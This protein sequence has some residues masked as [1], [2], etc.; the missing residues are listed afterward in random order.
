MFTFAIIGCGKIAA[1]HAR[2]IARVGKL[3]AVVDINKNKA[4]DFARD[5]QARSYYGIDDFLEKENEIDIVCVCT[6]NGC[7]AEHCIKSLQAGFHVLCEGPLC[8]TTAAAWQMIETEKFCR[9]KLVVTHSLSGQPSALALKQQI[10]ERIAGQ[11]FNFDLNCMAPA[12]PSGD[13]R[14]RVFPGGGALY[15]HFHR[16]ISLLLFLFGDI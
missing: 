11:T 8:I 7:H 16:Y 14:N 12:D 9:K 5:F 6:P 10:D 3:A 13:W 4:D 2:Q 15:T 1:A